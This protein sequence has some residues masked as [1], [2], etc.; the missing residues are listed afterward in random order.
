MKKI[1]VLHV[2]YSDNKGGAAIALQ[3][4]HN[5]CQEM[6]L[7]SRK[8]VAFGQDKKRGAF[9][10]Y[11]STRSRVRQKLNNLINKVVLKACDTP[12]GIGIIPSRL[13]VEINSTDVDIVHLH[14][15]GGGFMSLNDI[16]KINKPVVWTMHDMWIV[17]GMKHVIRLNEFYSSVGSKNEGFVE[18]K[19][20][21]FL[22]RMKQDI[23]NIYLICPSS[24]MYNLCDKSINCRKKFLIPN[25]IDSNKWKPVLSAKKTS[26]K[27]TIGYV[28][29]GGRN[30][31]WYKGFLYLEKVK[32][33]L[34][35]KNLN[36][37]FVVIGGKYENSSKGR[38]F[39][40]N[41]SEDHLIAAL[42]GMDIVVHPSLVDNLPNVVVESMSV[43]T[44]VVAFNVGGISDIVSHK[45][46]GY[47]SKCCDV[48]DM[49]KG[50][51]WS[52][53]NLDILKENA[54]KKIEN[55]FDS[56]VVS[57]RLLS[58][59]QEVLLDF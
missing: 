29:V 30:S 13:H 58:A 9:Q 4:T 21:K 33:A 11:L 7:D 41:L 28:S 55:E 6:G 3:R 44:P 54:R 40:G 53:C 14:W 37:E 38:S 36:V 27:I 47:L 1:K 25:P 48:D 10:T 45:V 39:L 2:G 23:P 12:A 22:V 49:V 52:L 35:S 17:S 34:D 5:M 16:K 50:I 20:N 57:G 43:G 15:L 24:W 19:I 51:E 8:L 32:K 42:S 56:V 18:K 46:D 26:A 59:Y 31:P